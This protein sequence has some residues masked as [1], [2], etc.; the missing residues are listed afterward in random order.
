MLRLTAPGGTAAMPL[1]AAVPSSTAL[2]PFLPAILPAA[3]SVLCSL[4]T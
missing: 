4:R 2:L 1:A 3:A